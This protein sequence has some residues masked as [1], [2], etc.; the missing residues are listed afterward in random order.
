MNAALTKSLALITSEQRTAITWAEQRHRGITNRLW[1]TN[2]LR[3]EFFLVRGHAFPAMAD[4]GDTFRRL[5]AAGVLRPTCFAP[6]H[7][8]AAFVGLQEGASKEGRG[9]PHA[10]DAGHWE[11]EVTGSFDVLGLETIVASVES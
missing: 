9:A 1:A 7:S 10:G 8:G 3:G 4:I 6:S 2:V 5:A 11:W